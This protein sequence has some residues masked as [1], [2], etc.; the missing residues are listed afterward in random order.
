MRKAVLFILV[1]LLS[2]T[3]VFSYAALP[4][5][6]RGNIAL[7]IENSTGN[8]LY[9]ENADKTVPIASITKVMTLLLTYEAI[10]SGKISADDMI[11]V[12]KNAADTS[13]SQAF[14]DEGSEYELSQLIKTVIIA[15]ANDSSVA[16]AEHIAGSESAFC[17][18]M[19]QRA[20]ELSME[21][22][23]FKTCTGLPAQGQYSTAK[24]VSIMAL[25][26]MKHEEY[27]T[28]STT[29]MDELVH[30]GGR[31]TELVNTNRLVRFYEGADGLKTGYSSEAGC[32]LCATAQ[33][34]D[35]RMTVVLLG[36]KDSQNRFADAQ[37]LLSYGFDEY[38]I[39]TIAKS[40]DTYC[41]LPLMGAKEKEIDII[42]HS[43]ITALV[44]R[45][46]EPGCV[47]EIT[48]P[49]ILSAPLYSDIEVGYIT[50]TYDNGNSLRYQLYPKNDIEKAGFM[51]ALTK[52][53]TRWS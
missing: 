53:I 27:F 9:E 8:I 5:E 36:Y 45:G 38:E 47:I 1:L 39:K 23:V 40:G 4:F 31:V 32:C 35:E 48:L 11:T 42:S 20:Q 12:S 43:D 52:I 50:V 24:D 22:T 28:H 26:L 51:A 19:N 33:R 16:I 46:S 13:G 25:E 17:E 2:L 34:G 21:N 6:L 10:E 37:K 49:E 15:S 14:L 44:H 41:T 18:L 30:P 3:P 29:W 7:L